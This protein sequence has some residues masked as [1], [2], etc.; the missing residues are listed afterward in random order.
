MVS[1]RK[2]YVCWHAV[3]LVLDKSC[4]THSADFTRGSRARS[5]VLFCSN[6]SCQTA[7]CESRWHGGPDALYLPFLWKS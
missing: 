4:N 2:Q 6:A 1:H 7:K 5:A 3:D